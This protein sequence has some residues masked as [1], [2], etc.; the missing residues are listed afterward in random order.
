MGQRALW[1]WI[2][3]RRYHS[4]GHLVK[5]KNLDHRGLVTLAPDH[6]SL[7][8]G[9]AMAPHVTIHMRPLPPVSLLK[10]NR[11]KWF[12]WFCSGADM[13]ILRTWNCSTDHNTHS[14]L[15]SHL[16]ITSPSALP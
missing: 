11:L 16:L 14:I 10:A 3:R 2:S 12:F 8:E 13:A 5:N 6:R 7:S 1:S 4:V 9:L 15:V